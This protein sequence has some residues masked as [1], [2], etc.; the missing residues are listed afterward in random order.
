RDRSRART[1]RR[2]RRGGDGRGRKL[3]AASGRP[4]E[5][6]RV[7]LVAGP[8]YDHVYDAFTPGEVEV[9]VHADHPTL[10]R[11]VARM[12]AAGTRIDVCAS[13]SKNAPSQG[14]WLRPLDAPRA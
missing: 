11:E 14:Q 3:T 12:L 6:L 2:S 1:D 4:R 8:M 9:V 5:P 7:A 13:H 10:N